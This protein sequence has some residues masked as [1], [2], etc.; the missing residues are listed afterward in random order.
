MICC[1][2]LDLQDL[3]RFHKRCYERGFVKQI[4]YNLMLFLLSIPHL[5]ALIETCF[6]FMLLA[7]ERLI[8]GIVSACRII[9]AKYDNNV[10]SVNSRTNFTY[11]GS[12]L[13]Y[14]S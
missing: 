10:T 4:C 1:Q 5:S 2:K 7:G 14:G 9:A 3:P 12:E 8:K 11:F 13:A 6:I